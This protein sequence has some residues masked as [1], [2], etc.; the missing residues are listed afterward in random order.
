MLPREDEELDEE[1]QKRVEKYPSIIRKE[2]KEDVRVYDVVLR[3]LGAVKIVSNQVHATYGVRLTVGPTHPNKNVT[4]F[5]KISK[6][7]HVTL[8]RSPIKSYGVPLLVQEVNPVDFML[9]LQV[10]KICDQLREYDKTMIY[11]LH[12]DAHDNLSEYYLRDE[13]S[14]NELLKATHNKKKKKKKLSAREKKIRYMAECEDG[15][16]KLIERFNH[17]TL[18]KDPKV[19]ELPKSGL[20][21]EQ[22]NAVRMALNPDRRIVC[23]QGPPGTGKTRTLAELISVAYRDGKKVLVCAP[24]HVAV[25]NVRS[26]T[27]NRFEELGFKYNKA[28]LQIGDYNDLEEM[29]EKHP[30]YEKILEMRDRQKE[31]SKRSQIFKI[32]RDIRKLHNRIQMQLAPELRVFFST[33]GAGFIMRLKDIWSP[34]IIILDEASQ[35]TEASVWPVLHCGKR[36]VLAGDHKQLPAVVRT[37]QAILEKFNVSLMERLMEENEGNNFILLKTQY[38]MNSSIMAWSSKIFYNEQLVAHESVENRSLRDVL[39]K[40]YHSDRTFGQVVMFNTDLDKEV[41][42]EETRETS[43]SNPSEAYLVA[44]HAWRLIQCGLNSAIIAIITPY[45]GQKFTIAGILATFKLNVGVFTIDEFQG[46]ERDVIVFSFVRNNLKTIGFLNDTRRG[47]VA[48]T[49]AKLQLCLVASGRMLEMHEHYQELFKGLKQG[50]G[51]LNPNIYFKLLPDR[52]VLSKNVV[53]KKNH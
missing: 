39:D 51:V 44:L 8:S 50:G 49:R 37:K 28:F 35:T 43:C 25:K 40:K 4:I 18:T 21:Q 27:I 53:S 15:M 47:N 41:S 2:V 31:A 30:S 11:Y 46:Q 23:I 13:P 34:D 24:S 5:S 14:R 17:L 19:A 10:K 52:G 16:G 38:R 26:A 32:E 33:L 3:Q 1:T 22:K 9:V 20:N 29:V 7:S 48:M 45:R 6:G 42:F 12:A 36:C